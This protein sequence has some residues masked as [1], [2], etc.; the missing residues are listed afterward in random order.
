MGGCISE[1]PMRKDSSCL[2]TELQISNDPSAREVS[3]AAQGIKMAQIVTGISGKMSCEF[4]QISQPGLVSV[5]K[6]ECYLESEVWRWIFSN[7]HH[8]SATLEHQLPHV[9]LHPHLYLCF[10]VQVCFTQW[11]S[12]NWVPSALIWFQSCWICCDAVYKIYLPNKHPQIH[13]PF[14]LLGTLL[15]WNLE[16]STQSPLILKVMAPVINNVEQSLLTMTF[17][18]QLKS[19]SHFRDVSCWRVFLFHFFDCL[20]LTEIFFQLVHF[21]NRHRIA[22]PWKA[23]VG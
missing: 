12:A 23:G 1:I 7:A 19:D 22:S 16:I 17:F 5:E 6:K 3:S 10:T 14:Q 8:S 2:S 18:H 4:L 21:G 20:H 13:P 11:P 15:H 9:W